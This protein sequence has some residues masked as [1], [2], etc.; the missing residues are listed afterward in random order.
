MGVAVH[1]VL[2]LY[3][4]DSVSGSKACILLTDILHY[5]EQS[6]L[7]VRGKSKKLTEKRDYNKINRQDTK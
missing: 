6:F 1:A 2:T 5:S 4:V 7:L 3:S